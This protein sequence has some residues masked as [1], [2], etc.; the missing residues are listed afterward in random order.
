MSCTALDARRCRRS[1]RRMARTLINIVVE[2]EGNVSVQPQEGAA[3]T[4][5]IKGG[6]IRLLDDLLESWCAATE[7]APAVV[8][9]CAVLP[10]GARVAPG[11]SDLAALQAVRR[12]A[13]AYVVQGGKDV[14]VDSSDGLISLQ[15]LLAKK[16]AE[17]PQTG[18]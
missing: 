18:P 10:Q 11:S 4:Q 6:L 15:E 16:A 14:V 7:T 1:L 12:F 17:E 5:I 9:K 8:G 2:D 13:S 3:S